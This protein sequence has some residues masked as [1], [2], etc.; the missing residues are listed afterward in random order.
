M[1][2]Q[3]HGGKGSAPRPMSVSQ[4]EYDSRWDAIFQRDLKKETDMN[5]QTET[6]VQESQGVACGCGR[7]PTGKCIGWHGLSEE[8]FRIKLAEFHA[9]KPEQA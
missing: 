3:W 7:S 8:D 4:A 6:Q 2:G 9:P 5:T 1:S